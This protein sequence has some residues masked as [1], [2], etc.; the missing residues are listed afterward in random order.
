MVWVHLGASLRSFQRGPWGENYFHNNIKIFFVFFCCNIYTVGA[1]VVLS[2]SASALAGI[3][4][5]TPKYTDNVYSSLPGTCRKKVSLKNKL[6]ESVKL[7][8]FILLNFDPWI[9]IFIIFSVIK[10]KIPIS[11]SFVAYWGFMA[12]SWKALWM[13]WVV[14][15]TSHFFS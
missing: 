12:V 2:S 7:L 10:W 14:S 8:I 13:V 9:C 6:D 3:R 1:K 15:W 5:V 4:A 11:C